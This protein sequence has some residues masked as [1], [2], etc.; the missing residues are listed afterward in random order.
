MPLPPIL[1]VED[2]PRVA[3]AL[4]LLLELHGL[5]SLAVEDPNAAVDVVSQR[6]VSVILQDMNF[7]PGAASGEEGVAL[8]RRLH[9][10]V[11]QVPILL[12]TAWGSIEHAVRLI[13]EGAC[14]YL[15][16]P[17]DDEKLIERIQSLLRQR[18]P[19]APRS[20]DASRRQLSRSHDLEG[21]IYASSALHEVVELALKVARAEVPILITGP[22]G[23]GKERIAELVQRNSNRAQEPFVRVNVGALPDALLEAEL[24]GS[25]AGAYTGASKR[26]TGRFEAA[27]G[28]TLLLDEIGNLSA[29]GQA[30]LLRVLQTGQFERL[31]SSATRQVD[32]RIL[33]A[34]NADLPAA[35]ARG[36]FREDLYFRLNVIELRVPAL[37]ERPDDILP[38]AE[39]F[40]RQLTPRGQG[41]LRL[42]EAARRKLI[43]HP[44]PGNVRELRNAIQRAVLVASGQVL[45]PADLGLGPAGSPPAHSGTIGSHPEPAADSGEDSPEDAEER[46]E[47]EAALLAADGVVAQAAASLGISRQALYRRM[48]RL[49]IVL[50]RRPRRDPS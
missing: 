2:Q 4:A 26:R 31:G 17:W 10:L 28:G 11:P 14:D 21:L 7:S 48:Q 12:L 50:E 16:K 45:Q 23:S 6:E 34:T 20:V 8:F 32:V 36:E 30:K 38:L 41:P 29:D 33:A 25:E 44:W 43:A 27:H 37:A 19:E 9:A 39:E 3:K 47:T 15:E 5:P 13:Q 18:G 46:R 35:I 1:I 42:S 24:F 40:V 49:G 22:N